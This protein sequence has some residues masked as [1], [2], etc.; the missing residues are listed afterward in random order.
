M[1]PCVINANCDRSAHAHDDSGEWHVFRDRN[2]RPAGRTLVAATVEFAEV[3]AY[4]E[5]RQRTAVAASEAAER[6]E[7]ERLAPERLADLC[8]KKS[9]KLQVRAALMRAGIGGSDPR[10]AAVDAE[11]ADLDASIRAEV[12]VAEP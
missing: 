6:A 10:V 2:G 4:E 8:M 7:A 5:D 11:V 3:L 1:S 9:A 12:G